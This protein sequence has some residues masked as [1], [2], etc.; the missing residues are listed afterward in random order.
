[1]VPGVAVVGLAEWV[2]IVNDGVHVSRPQPDGVYHLIY[3][4]VW[5]YGIS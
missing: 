1:M 5:R 3:V 2:Y 4:H